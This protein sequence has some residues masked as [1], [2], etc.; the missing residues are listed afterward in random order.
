MRNSFSDDP[1]LL[2]DFLQFVNFGDSVRVA[3]GSLLVLFHFLVGISHAF[4]GNG[5]LKS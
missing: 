1:D 2:R 5:G 3:L 4:F